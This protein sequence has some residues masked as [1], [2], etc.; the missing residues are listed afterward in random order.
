MLRFERFGGSLEEW[1]RILDTFP[2]RQIFQTAA[3][4]RF[5]AEAQNA[6]PV[7]AVLKQ[8]NDE[9]S[10]HQSGDPQRSAPRA[11]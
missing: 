3:W 5:V 1:E 2:D 7:I 10:I 8:G 11:A 9:T 6:R 4:L